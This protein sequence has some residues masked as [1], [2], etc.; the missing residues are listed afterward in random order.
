MIVNF[1][2][3]P[4]NSIIYTASLIIKYLKEDESHRNF[5]ELFRY[6]MN[7]KMEYSIF[8][9]SIDWLYLIGIIKEINEKNEVILCD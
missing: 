8:I 6:C 1:D 4:R 2:E 7:T 9:L 3:D 5:E